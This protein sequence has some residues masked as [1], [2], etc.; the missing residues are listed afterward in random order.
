[1]LIVC[2]LGTLAGSVG[3]ALAPSLRWLAAARAVTGV[4]GAQAALAQTVAVDVSTPQR[5]AANVG[6]LG[7]AFGLALTLG[8]AFGGVLSGAISASAVGWLC[9]GMQAVSLLIILCSLRETRPAERAPRDGQIRARWFEAL[10]LGRLVLVLLITFM[11]TMAV[12]EMLPTFSAVAQR[13]YRYDERGAGLMFACFGLLGVLVQGVVVR[14]AVPRVGE[15][16]TTVAGL[17]ILGCGLAAVAMQPGELGFWLATMFMSVGV[18]LATPCVTSLTSQAAPDHLQASIMG[19][20]QAV[21]GSGRA[22][23]NWLGGSLLE[24]HGIVHAYGSA[25]AASILGA[26]LTPLLALWR[27]SMRAAGNR[28]Q[29]DLGVSVNVAE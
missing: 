21:T 17:L 26:L 4:F 8:P 16:V 25:A 6:I 22:A 9:A 14:A 23:G 12:S 19:V 10:S 20:S 15:V 27:G 7:A 2:T 3:W 13:L 29:H 24:S 5:R 1:M 18:S 11:M 28:P